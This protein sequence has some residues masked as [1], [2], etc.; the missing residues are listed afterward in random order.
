MAGYFTRIWSTPLREAAPV[1]V[2]DLDSGD[3]SIPI[4]KKTITE[5]KPDGE[6]GGW[7]DK[8]F[9]DPGFAA[10]HR[11]LALSRPFPGLTPGR[12]PILPDDQAANP[13][14]LP[15]RSSNEAPVLECGTGSSPP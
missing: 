11:G 9:P 12:P 14:P 1:V 2:F 3:I 8:R 4:S 10:L 7:G 6:M 5:K 13:V 15:T